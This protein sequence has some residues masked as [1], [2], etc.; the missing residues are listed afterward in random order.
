MR[1]LGGHLMTNLVE[2]PRLTEYEDPGPGWRAVRSQSGEILKPVIKC[3]CGFHVGI[4]LHHVHEDG[5]VTAS[6]YHSKECDPER[7]CGWHVFL[8]LLDYD[9]GEFLPDEPRG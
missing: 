3:R 9:Q 1:F 2:I 7:G 8:K 5:R 6:F 4:G